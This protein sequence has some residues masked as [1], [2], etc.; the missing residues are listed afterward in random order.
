M[1]QYN[2]K[3]E[4]INFSVGFVEKLKRLR[5]KISKGKI[6][7]APGAAV[8]KHNTKELKS[9]IGLLHMCYTNLLY[10]RNGSDKLMKKEGRGAYKEYAGA[11]DEEVERGEREGVSVEVKEELNDE[12]SEDGDVGGVDAWVNGDQQDEVIELGEEFAE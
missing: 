3:Q 1:P 11:D 4:D 6:L 2:N 9:S 12:L 8:G 5:G 10:S 7:A